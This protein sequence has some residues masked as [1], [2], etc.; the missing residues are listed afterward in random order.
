MFVATR[1]GC[2]DDPVPIPRV[3]HANIA[4]YYV[5]QPGKVIARSVCVRIFTCKDTRSPDGLDTAEHSLLGG[6]FCPA[7]PSKCVAPM[8]R[9]CLM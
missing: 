3:Q 7:P 5:H 2:S 4:L 6:H 8:C 9:A 1:R